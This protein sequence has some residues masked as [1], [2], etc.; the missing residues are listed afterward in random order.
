MEVIF[1]TTL[2]SVVFAILFLLFFLRMRQNEDSCADQDALLPFKGDELEVT[3]V[4]PTNLSTDLN[5]ANS[6]D[7]R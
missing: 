1:L 5:P 2:F 7:Q 4:D 6:N 3:T